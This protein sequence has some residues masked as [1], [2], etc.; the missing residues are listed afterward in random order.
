MSKEDSYQ[1]LIRDF[2][3]SGGRNPKDTE[4]EAWETGYDSG[5]RDAYKMMKKGIK[6]AKPDLSFSNNPLRRG[7]PVQ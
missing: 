6:M 1:K 2:N 5:V 4:I 7:N 3:H